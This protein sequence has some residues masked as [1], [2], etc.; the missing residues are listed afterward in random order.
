MADTEELVGRLNR[1]TA[2]LR[3]QKT[4]TCL[5][6]YEDRCE[7]A[8]DLS[9]AAK[10][11]EERTRELEEVRKARDE[12]AHLMSQYAREAGEATGR[13]EMSEAA[14]IVDGWRERAQAAERLAD[15]L[16]GVLSEIIGSTDGYFTVS[17]PASLRE[18][19][20]AVC[21]LLSRARERKG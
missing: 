2:Q 21:S 4:A 3:D 5:A 19:A 10:L 8:Q 6:D 13:L 15:E 18:R 1:R 20:Q 16:A 17:M 11:L 14:G 7:L 12:A 9:E